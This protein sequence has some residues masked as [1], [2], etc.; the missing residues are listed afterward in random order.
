MIFKQGKEYN[1]MPHDGKVIKRIYR[2]GKCYYIISPYSKEA[3]SALRAAFPA[4]LNV[5]KDYGYAHPE[6]VG[7][8]NAYAVEDPKIAYS[9]VPTL[10]VIRSIKSLGSAWF[11]TGLQNESND[12]EYYCEWKEYRDSE[13]WSLF[14]STGASSTPGRWSAVWYHPSSTSIYSA[15]GN[16]DGLMSNSYTVNGWNTLAAKYQNGAAIATLNGNALIGT[17]IGSVQNNRN[18][19]LF[20]DKNASSAQE[21]AP[22]GIE[23]RIWQKKESNATHTIVPFIRNGASEL[24]ILETGDLCTKYGDFT[25]SESPA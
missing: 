6:I 13:K 2:G 5:I 15:T 22:S 8:M 14:G 25:I 16:T 10:N 21:I 24:L 17:Y 20:A 12:V 11:D 7:Y 18:I 4:Q 23:L 19:A 9:L 3:T 1:A